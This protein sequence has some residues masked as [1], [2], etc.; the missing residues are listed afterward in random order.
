MALPVKQPVNISFEKGL[1]LKVDP[2]QIPVGS[3]LSLINSVFDKVGRLTKRNGF[4]QLT[5]L[6]SGTKSSYL[7]TFQGGLQALGTNILSY[8]S[9]TMSWGNKG[10]THPLK[11]GT[12]SLIKNSLNQS[13]VDCAIAPNN[14]ICI[15]YTETTGSQVFYKY[16]VADSITG[17]NIIEPT[18]IPVTSGTVTNSPRVFLLGSNFII[19]FENVITAVHYLQYVA[20]SISTGLVTKTNT[21]I[22]N[23]FSNSTTLAFDAAVA[24]GNLY[25]AWNGAAASGIKMAYLTASLS[26]SVTI[27]EDAAHQATLMSVCVDN[28]LSSPVI[29]ASYYNSGTQNGYTLTIDT[30]LALI[31]APTQFIFSK[32]VLNLTATASLGTLFTFY[33]IDH[34]YSYDSGIP[35]H[36]VLTRG[37][38]YTGSLGAE[39]TSLR[40]VGLAS[41]AMYYN[42]NAYYLAVYDSPYQPTYFLVE[43]DSLS[44][45]PKPVAKLAYSNGGGYLETGLPNILMVES[46][47]FKVPY[48]FKDLI[49]AVNKNTN[50][51]SG[52]QVNGIYSQTGINLAEFTFTTDSLTSVEIGS[53]LQLSGGFL[54][55]FDG[56]I[57]VES[58]FFLYPDSVEVTS[59]GTTGSMTAGTYFYQVTYEWSDNQGNSFKSAP[60]IPVSVT[61]TTDTSVDIDI[62]TLRLTYKIASPVKIVI[63][64]WSAAQPIYYQTTSITSPQL[65]NSTIDSISYN[66]KNSDATILG[67]NVL[68]TTGGVIENIAPPA[69]NILTLFDTRLW[70]VDAE[71]PNL[72]WFSKQVI[73]ATPVEMSDLFTLFIAPTIGAQGSTGDTTA[74][75]PMDDKLIIFKKEAIYYINGTGPDNTGANNNYSQPIFITSTVGC[76][77]PRSIVMM[78]YGLMF[79][80]DKGIWLLGRDL[81]TKY[82]GAEVEDF[83]EFLVTSAQAIPGTNQ[84][85]FAL[86]N[87]ITL[88]YDYFVGQ[89]G[90]FDGIPSLSSTLFNETHTIIDKYGRVLQERPGTYLD[91]SSPVLMSFK[92]SWLQL[93]AL[94]GYQRAYWFYILGTYLSPH[95]LQIEV[96]YDYNSSASQSN[97]YTPTNTFQLYGDDPY[98]GG[99][100]ATPYGGTGNIEQFRMFFERQRCKAFQLT[101]SEV[102]DPSFNTVA[103]PGLTLSGL[104]V[105]AAYKKSYAPIPSNNQVG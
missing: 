100:G 9:N 20:I 60:S 3:F 81:S 84:V 68:Y 76:T 85:R 51:P 62:P 48:L 96:A 14:N 43:G 22:S 89:W 34:S 19:L 40:S 27:I 4:P 32:V 55:M 46:N 93:A 66:D 10:S 50:V 92:T 42:G 45:S 56:Y 73:E 28:T 69:S 26:V 80:S 5:S 95:K 35:S 71:D 1:N 24:N 47:V 83:N 8:F 63:Y 38:S 74:L 31:L 88:M 12:T 36:F 39:L 49:Q 104:N 90:E 72:L 79:Q 61:L 44:S 41:K 52:S 30:A 21:D 29:R 33:E 54:W 58:N 105:I 82:L 57:P 91:A 75:A 65:N 13:Q 18:V 86:D 98:Y 16:S 97:L 6:P 17:Q 87:G 77:N 53:D 101:I 59:S 37:V 7:T 15:V 11:V 2:Y 23:S 102:F 25:V 99:N 64:R 70:L 103:G 67:N 94:R 78:P